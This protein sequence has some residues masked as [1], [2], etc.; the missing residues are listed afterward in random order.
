[1]NAR[2]AANLLR[3]LCSVHTFENRVFLSLS[4]KVAAF[5]CFGCLDLALCGLD[6]ARGL[7]STEQTQIVFSGVA[8][9][10][11]SS[12]SVTAGSDKCV[13]E[14]SVYV[15]LAPSVH[16]DL[17]HSE[18]I[19]ASSHTFIATQGCTASQATVTSFPRPLSCAASG[20]SKSVCWHLQEEGSHPR[21]ILAGKL[22]PSSEP[23]VLMASTK[24]FTSR[25]A[26][27]KFFRN[28][29]LSVPTP[30]KCFEAHRVT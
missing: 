22:S 3:T 21:Y 15:H 7:L 14:P 5:F 18:G 25:M 10:G 16:V 11:T 26:G 2:K 28:Q 9:R 23:P 6:V 1:M 8:V 19:A 24:A 30:S 4:G 29:S 27:M 20:T 13:V 17:E 12:W